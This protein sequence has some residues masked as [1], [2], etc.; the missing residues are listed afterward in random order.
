MALVMAS[1][2]PLLSPDACKV[3]ERARFSRADSLNLDILAF[4]GGEDSV[5]EADVGAV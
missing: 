5:V 1:A 3:F 4:C 2:A